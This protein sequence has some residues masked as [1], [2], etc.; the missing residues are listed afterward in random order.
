MPHSLKQRKDQEKRGCYFAGRR[1]P[2]CS[3]L[4]R[5]LRTEQQLREKLSAL[6]QQKMAIDAEVVAVVDADGFRRVDPTELERICQA[7][8][9]RRM[10]RPDGPVARMGQ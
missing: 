1:A 10:Q 7:V 9:D 8:V 4:P 6:Q 5:R 3:E 2:H